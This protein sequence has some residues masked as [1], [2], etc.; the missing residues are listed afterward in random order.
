MGGVELEDIVGFPFDQDRPESD[1][2]ESV[3]DDSMTAT[4]MAAK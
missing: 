2:Q 1:R 4:Y 3:I